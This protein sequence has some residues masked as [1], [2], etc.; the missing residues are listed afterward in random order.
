MEKGRCEDLMSQQLVRLLIKQ[1]QMVE[2]QVQMDE[3][4]REAL[5]KLIVLLNSEHIDLN[6]LNQITS[7]GLVDI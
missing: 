2:F 7:L 1:N 6:A 3:P 5:E 4:V